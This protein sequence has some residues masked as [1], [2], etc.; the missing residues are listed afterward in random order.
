MASTAHAP[1]IRALPS[2]EAGDHLDQVTFHARYAAMPASFRA[3]LIGGMVIVPSPLSRGHGLHHML[4]NGWLCQYWLATPGTLAWDNVT[5]ILSEEDE[6]QPDAGLIIE[7]A[8]GGQTGVTEDDYTIG[9]PELIVEIASSSASMD[10]HAKRRVYEQAGVQEYVVV[11]LRQ[12]A[13]RWFVRQEGVYEPMAAEADGVYK[14]RLF[15]GLW[16]H[17]ESLLHLDG[18]QLMAVLQQGLATPEHAALVQEL[19]ARRTSA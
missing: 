18:G 8:C 9:A 15:P 2:V 10:L 3:E 6:V 19:Q 12:R 17:A 1:T 16:L 7:P 4:I 11:V 5:T 14:S 13:I